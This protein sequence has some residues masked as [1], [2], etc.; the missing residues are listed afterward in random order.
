MTAH[1]GELIKKMGD[2]HLF[3]FASALDAVLAGIRLQKALKRFNYYREEVRRVVVRVG[4]HWGKII[5]KEGDVLG[6]H[7]NIASR[8]E[9]SAAGGSVFVSQAVHDRLGGRVHSREVGPVSVK[10]FADPIRVYEPYETAIDFPKELDPLNAGPGSAPQPR[11]EA[12]TASP[13]SGADASAIRHGSHPGVVLDKKAVVFIVETFSRL[14]GLCHKASLN[15]ASV[16][17]IR[18]ELIGRWKELRKVLAS[19]VH[20]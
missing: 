18:R 6:N 9:S 16:D 2:G 12:V 7:V 19:G 13:I 5:R 4:I 14:N 3:V 8:L 17:D 11:D 1:R 10:G 15:E 20:Q